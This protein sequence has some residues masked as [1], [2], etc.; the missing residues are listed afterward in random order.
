M[1]RRFAQFAGP[2]AAGPQ[3]RR[4]GGTT[5]AEP[6]RQPFAF[7]LPVHTIWR[8]TLNLPLLRWIVGE[9]MALHYPPQHP[10]ISNGGPVDWIS[11]A[12]LL[13]RREALEQVGGFDEGFFMY[14]D[15]TDLCRS[16]WAAGWH[17]VYAPAIEVVHHGEKSS[18]KVWGRM[19]V[20]MQRSR[21]R[22]LSKHYGTMGR[23]VVRLL[24]FLFAA[25]RFA[26]WTLMGK[27]G[28][29]RTEGAILRL[30][31]TGP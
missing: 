24:I 31:V 14:F 6:G 16:L 21:L 13:A 3:R 12:C 29:L 27:W 2:A 15:D 28:R 10:S 5:A 17:V 1:Q 25:L 22:Y 19:L 26:A 4:R 8:P 7:L 18:R 30:A 20:E 9:R 11:G 23:G